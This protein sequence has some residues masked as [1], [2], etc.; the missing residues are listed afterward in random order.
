[1]SE[2]FPNSGEALGH[3]SGWAPNPERVRAADVLWPTLYVWNR[4]TAAVVL[5]GQQSPD[6]NGTLTLLQVIKQTQALGNDSRVWTSLD[7]TFGF[8]TTWTPR[9]TPNMISQQ[10]GH[11]PQSDVSLYRSH[12]PATA[13]AIV[14]DDWIR[15]ERR[16][17]AFMLFTFNKKENTSSQAVYADQR[18]P[19]SEIWVTEH[20]NCGLMQTQLNSR[21]VCLLRREALVSL[22]LTGSTK[23]SP[24]KLSRRWGV[25][26]HS[27]PKG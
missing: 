22:V 27:L 15:W 20:P 18:A 2:H 16:P 9:L 21:P 6:R 23:Q 13:Q 17:V 4:L 7:G 1:M 24:S 8:N 5:R 10:K 11:D 26:A 12:A 19:P 3:F 25:F 14:R